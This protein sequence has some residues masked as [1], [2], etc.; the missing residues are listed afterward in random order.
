MLHGSSMPP[1]VSVVYGNNQNTNALSIRFKHTN[2]QTPY[3]GL[4]WTNLMIIIERRMFIVFI[5]ISYFVN[6]IRYKPVAGVQPKR[7]SERLRLN[8]KTNC[9]YAIAS[10][11][12]IY[13]LCSCL[14]FGVVGGVNG[15][16][17]V[18]S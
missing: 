3:C 2:P 10:I 6:N 11:F 13:P 8:I 17:L 9:Q 16:L 5:Q 15:C 4:L 7:L 14:T 18:F 1:P 12:N